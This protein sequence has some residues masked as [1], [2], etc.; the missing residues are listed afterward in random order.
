MYYYMSA[1][2]AKQGKNVIYLQSKIKLKGCEGLIAFPDIVEYIG[3]NP[4]TQP[5]YDIQKE[6]IYDKSEQPSEFH[7]YINGEWVV[8][9][10]YG[11]KTIIRDKFKKEKEAKIYSEIKISESEGIQFREKDILNILDCVSIIKLK[12]SSEK[13]TINWI[14]SDNSIKKITYEDIENLY[15][16]YLI[17]KKKVVEKYILINQKIES[18]ETETELIEI[19][20]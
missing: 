5:A 3:D 9:N 12:L 18:A 2:S 6:V 11:Y 4:P 16:L 1:E 13:D 7:S 14:M 15:K 19:T 10:F 20:W 8:S 17:R